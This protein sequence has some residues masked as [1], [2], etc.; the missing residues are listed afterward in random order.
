MAGPLAAPR[1]PARPGPGPTPDALLRALDISVGR[2][3]RG[4]VPGEFRALDLGGGT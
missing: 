4:L 3:I 1:T 2:R